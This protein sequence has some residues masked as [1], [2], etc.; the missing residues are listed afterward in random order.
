MQ[1]TRIYEK[2]RKK[3]QKNPTMNYK[4]KNSQNNQNLETQPW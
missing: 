1:I 2:K 4:L 3:K